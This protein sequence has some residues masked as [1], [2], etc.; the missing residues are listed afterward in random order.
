MAQVEKGSVQK[1]EEKWLE[2]MGFTFEVVK[3]KPTKVVYKVEKEG[4]SF[5]TELPKALACKVGDYMQNVEQLWAM[6]KI[7]QSRM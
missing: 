4:I 2:R 3:T 1:A 6:R 7:L 5:E